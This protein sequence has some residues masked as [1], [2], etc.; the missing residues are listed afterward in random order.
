MKS[1]LDSELSSFQ[2]TALCQ[3]ISTF[4]NR[5]LSFYQRQ[6]TLMDPAARGPMRQLFAEVLTRRHPPELSDECVR[7]GF[8]FTP[9]LQRK[10]H[11]ASSD[12]FR[13]RIGELGIQRLK[14][15]NFWRVFPDV[16][17]STRPF[18]SLRFGA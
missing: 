17:P 4:C 3:D 12:F 1:V 8:D 14:A 10:V 7:P 6:E 16:S 5:L 11:V 13:Q 15:D 2:K 18:V 9:Y